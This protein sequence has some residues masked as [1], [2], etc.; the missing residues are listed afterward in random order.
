MFRIG[1]EEFIILNVTENPEDSVQL[2][3]KL[4]ELTDK[5]PANYQGVVVPST[6]SAGISCCAGASG[7]GTLSHL[8]RAADKALYEAKAGGRNRVVLHSSCK[9]A[10]ASVRARGAMSLVKSEMAH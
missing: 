4:R 5:S 10:A 3:N 7:G 6:V 9:E 2:A 1:G 8:M